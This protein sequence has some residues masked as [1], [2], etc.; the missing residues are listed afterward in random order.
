MRPPERW[1]LHPPPVEAEALTSWLQRTASRYGLYS[2]ELFDHDLGHPGVREPGLDLDPPAPLLTELAKRTG[3]SHH[4]LAA[5]TMAGWMPWLFDSLAPSP[6][7]YETYVHQ[8]SVLLPPNQRKIYTPGRWLPWLTESGTRRGCPDCLES[9]PEMLLFW[10][11]PVMASCPLHKRLL[12]THEGIIDDDVLWTTPGHDQSAVPEALSLMDRRTWEAITTGSVDLPRRSVHAGI[13]FRLL[14]TLLDELST[15]QGRYGRQLGEV[16]R[17]WECC[18]HP[19]RAGL[20]TWRPFEELQGNTQQQLLEAAALAMEMIEAGSL[21]ALGA[22]AHLLQPEPESR[23]SDGTPPATSAEDADDQKE[24]SLNVM[25]NRVVDSLDDAVEAAREDPAV[26]RQLYD[27]TVYG[28][29]DEESVLRLRETF[30]ELG[31]PAEPVSYD[32]E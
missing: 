18:G 20:H 30:A 13:W 27:C 28:C 22:S 6:D 21:T 7:G 29:R 10:Q 26:A 9:S 5:M 17:L 25:W 15:T 24:P 4:R 2:I 8:L 1:P 12:E 14:R 23:I 31:I 32:V 16:R 19:F 3:L 11:L